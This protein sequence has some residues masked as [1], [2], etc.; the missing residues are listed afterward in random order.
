M[1]NKDSREASPYYKNL[2]QFKFGHGERTYRQL[3]FLR[4]TEPTMVQVSPQPQSPTTSSAKAASITAVA[5]PAHG[6]GV[7]SPPVGPG[8]PDKPPPAIAP[9]QPSASQ[10]S[11]SGR[12]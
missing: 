11:S 8:S 2:R 5:S 7:K 9:L 10:S 4:S 3:T 12:V 1:G 6:A